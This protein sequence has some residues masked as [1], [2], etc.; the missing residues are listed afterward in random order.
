VD[1]GYDAGM[2]EVRVRDVV[3][4][5]PEPVKVPIKAAAVRTVEASAPASG[6]RDG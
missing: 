4:P 6:T 3:R 1:A 5:D 2:L